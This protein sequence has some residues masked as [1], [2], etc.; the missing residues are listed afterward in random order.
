MFVW[1]QGVQGLSIKRHK[2][3]SWSNLKILYFG[4]GSGYTVI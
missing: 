2:G 4:N 1:G 3:L